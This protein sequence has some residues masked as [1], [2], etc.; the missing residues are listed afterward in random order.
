ML[1][2]KVPNVTSAEVLQRCLQL[3]LEIRLERQ[4]RNPVSRHWHL[5]LPGKHGTL[6]VTEMPQA[7]YLKVHPLRDG[8]WASALASELAHE[9]GRGERSKQP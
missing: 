8:G 4:S 2:L 3:G 9:F 7:V 1:E 5:G 6:E